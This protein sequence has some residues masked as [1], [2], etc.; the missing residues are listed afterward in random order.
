[1]HDPLTIAICRR[2]CR[3]PRHQG[4][5]QGVLPMPRRRVDHQTRGFIDD[6]EVVVLEGDIEGDGMGL[7][8]TDR[9][10]LGKHDR[11]GV[12]EGQPAAG[13]RRGAVHTHGSPRDEPCR[14]GARNGKL[15]S[16]KTV[17]PLCRLNRHM[18]RTRVG[19][20]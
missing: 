16:E 14:L 11:N 4:I 18:D 19:H 9:F 1:M 17:E 8:L 20:L 2:Q 13:P 3:A 10:P 5:H 6:E 15:V 7:D 12:S